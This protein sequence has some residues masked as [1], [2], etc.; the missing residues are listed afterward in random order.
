MEIVLYVLSKFCTLSIQEANSFSYSMCVLHYLLYRV[1]SCLC[2]DAW[3]PAVCLFCVT[4]VS[5]YV[6]VFIFFC[7]FHL[8]YTATGLT[9]L[10]AFLI[11]LN[12]DKS[13]FFTS[14]AWWNVMEFFRILSW[15]Y[16][17]RVWMPH[18]PRKICLG[19]KGYIWEVWIWIHPIWIHNGRQRAKSM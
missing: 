8:P 14:P 7:V 3:D 17:C 5:R 19:H 13:V 11:M 4:S 18:L 15:N 6:P 10:A 9:G 12:T 2:N 1:N 16:T